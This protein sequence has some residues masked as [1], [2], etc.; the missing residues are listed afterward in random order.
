MI[1]MHARRVMWF[2]LEYLGR[3]RLC[4]GSEWQ[5]KFDDGKY[6][7]INWF[8]TKSLELSHYVTRFNHFVCQS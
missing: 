7:S 4:D 5:F 3:L 2:D 1:I 8:K 6:V